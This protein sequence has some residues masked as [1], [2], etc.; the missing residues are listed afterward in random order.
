M[1]AKFLQTDNSLQI[2]LAACALDPDE[3]VT[4]YTV[5]RNSLVRFFELKGDSDPEE[6]ADVTLDRAAQK[7][8]QNVAVENLTNYCFGIARLVFLERVRAAQKGKIAA[9]EFQ[10]NQIASAADDE[11]TDDFEVFRECFETLPDAQRNLLQKYFAAEPFAEIAAHRAKLCREYNVSLNNLRL[12]VF[13]LRQTL[14]NCVK[15]KL[16]QK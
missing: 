16:R 10:Q 4:I 2:L 7:L 11:T 6:A 1:P 13:R 9:E 12:K 5:L 8:A 15:N 3:A 14:E